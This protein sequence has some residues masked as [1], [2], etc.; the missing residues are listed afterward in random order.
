MTASQA[1]NRQYPKSFWVIWAVE[2]WER[3]GYYGTQA[4]LAVYF[5][6]HLGYSDK[7]SFYVFGSFAAFVYGFV[8]IGGWVGDKYIGAK[9]TLLLGAIVLMLSYLSLALADKDTIFYALAG[10][11]IGNA[12]FKANPSSLVSKIYKGD[13][14]GL[15]AAMTVYYMAIN[16]G[17]FLSMSMTPVIAH[18]LGWHWAFATCSLGLF[19]GIINY[20]TFYR[21]LSN[22]SSEAGQNVMSWGRVAI[23]LAGSIIAIIIIA[24]ILPR[25]TLCYSIIYAVVAGGFL[26]YLKIAFGLRGKERTRMLV[27]FVLI[28]EG[29]IFYTLYFQAPMSLTFLA[30]H[31][32]D[33]VVLGYQIPAASYQVLNPLMI[34]LMTPVLAFIYHRRH[35]THVTKFCWGMTLC[36][37]AFLVLWLP[38]FVSPQGT[39]SSWWMILT[40][41]LQSTGELLIS[42]LGLAMVAE[43]CP[44]AISGFVMGIWFLASMMAGPLSG[45]LSG[46]TTPSKEVA[47]TLTKSQGLQLYCEVFGIIGIVTGLIALVMWLFRPA[48]NRFIEQEHIEEDKS[49]EIKEEP[50]V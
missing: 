22:L 6:Q 5:V 28:L 17:S 16:I 32:V 48:L 35:S 20:M 41:W 40:Y 14:Q 9:R 46:L 27:G 1:K 31:N 50:H 29:I 38:Q 8:W 7:E 37:L 15:D 4:I 2:F 12:L 13:P 43:L 47:K 44:K 39:I 26:Y 34:V 45:W 36:S 49:L 33:R 42:A 24:Q 25:T 21:H 3:F 18:H 19:L 30:M 23:V 11:I 10:V